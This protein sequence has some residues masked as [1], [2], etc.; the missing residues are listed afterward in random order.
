MPKLIHLLYIS[1]SVGQPD[2]V[3][4]DEILVQARN[5]NARQKI[6]GMLLY[7][8]GTFIQ[9]LEGNDEDVHEI[10]SD[11]EKDSR[12]TNVIKLLD[13]VVAHRNF[14]DWTMGFKRLDDEKPDGWV[15]IF[16]GN[17]D[18]ELLYKNRSFLI[19]VMLGFSNNK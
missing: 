1:R 7:K 12:H 10:F 3:E 4:L 11:I 17:Y 9:V 2:Q 14:P 16:S 6:T 19:N 5:R 8:S 13:E 15:D 18:Q